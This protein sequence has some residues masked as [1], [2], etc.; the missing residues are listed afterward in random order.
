MLARIPGKCFNGFNDEIEPLMLLEK[1]G[2]NVGP[3]G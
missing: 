3:L 2:R 1:G